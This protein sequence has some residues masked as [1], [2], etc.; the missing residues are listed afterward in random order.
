MSLFG[1]TRKL[2]IEPWENVKERFRGAD[3]LLGNGFSINI[4]STFSYQ[5]LF[6]EFLKTCYPREKE[7]FAKFNTTNFED[8]MKSLGDAATVNN[9]SG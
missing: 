4:S 3:L 5:S 2:Q 6:N 1:T 7:I 8:I 9:R